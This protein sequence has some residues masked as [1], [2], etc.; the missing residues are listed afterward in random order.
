[1]P[2][3]A[4]VF[5]AWQS[6]AA[7]ATTGAVTVPM[8]SPTCVT[9][10]PT[11]A[12]T[13][14]ASGGIAGKECTFAIVTSGTSSFVLTWGTNFKTVGTLATGAVSGKRFSVTFRCVDGILWQETG[15]TAA[16]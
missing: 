8:T 3:I 7:P 4:N 11:G 9:I 10:A 6:A 15:R 12:C 5:S 2:V 14:N 13:F 1:M 16:M